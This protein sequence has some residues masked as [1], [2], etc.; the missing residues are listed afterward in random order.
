VTIRKFF[1]YEEETK[2]KV[3]RTVSK[4]SSSSTPTVRRAKVVKETLPPCE[5]CGLYKT[6]R[7]PKMGVTGEGR[8]GILFLAEAAGS[9]EDKLGYQLCGQAGQ[10]FRDEII[11]PL[12]YDLDAD[13]YKCNVVRCRPISETG[14]NRTPTDRE[15]ALCHGETWQ[16]I[17]DRRPK[18]IILTGRVPLQS[19]LLDIEI[20]GE[21]PAISRWADWCIP[22]R[23][24]KC[25]VIPQY[26]PSFFQYGS[27]K[28]LL[29][30]YR[31]KMEVAIGNSLKPFPE[32]TREED[33]IRCIFSPEEAIQVLETILRDKPPLLTLD[34]ETTGLK[35]YKTG[36][37]IV[38]VGLSWNP[39]QGVSFPMFPEIV[40]LLR[41]ILKN[42]DIKKTAHNFKFEELWA[43]Q[44]LETSIKGWKWC[45]QLATHVLDDR[46]GIKSLAFQTFVRYGIAGFKD[47][48]SP[49]MKSETSN[50]LNNI[51]ACPIDKLLLRNGLDAM[52]AHRLALDQ[53][54]ELKQIKGLTG[55][56]NLFH[57]GSLAF[58]DSEITGIRTS[59]AYF[60]EVQKG[61]EDECKVAK[62]NIM[63]SHYAKLWEK[64]TGV[65]LNP[66]SPD[67]LKKLLFNTLGVKPLKYTA[68]K[69]P[70]LDKADIDELA[71]T[72]S[73]KSLRT[74]LKNITILRTSTKTESTY[75]R[76]LMKE[77]YDDTIHPFFHLD[78]VRSYR[79]S[80]QNPNFQNI[81]VRNERMMLLVRNGIFPHPGQQLLEVDFGMHEVR[82]A[83]CFT[84]DP[85]LIHYCEDPTSD[86]HRDQT[87]RI[88]LLQKDRINKPI[89]N[90][91]KGGFVFAQFY[92]SWYA[93]CAEN[94]WKWSDDLTLE[95]GMP[96]HTHLKSK[97]ISTLDDFS[98][99][100]RAEEDHFWKKFSVY[101]QWK[102]KWV[103]KYYETGKVLL[104][105]GF[106]RQGFL[107]RNQILNTAIQG[108]A[109]HLLLWSFIELMKIA[110]KEDWKSRI[111]AQIHDCILFSVAPSE[112]Q[113][114][115]KL[116]HYITTAAI[117]KPHPWLNVPLDV[118]YELSG[119]DQPWAAKEKISLDKILLENY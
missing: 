73:Q 24:L 97:G 84:Q 96:I 83:A 109:F 54:E 62:E 61:M 42:L 56:Y 45:S 5:E 107:D 7:S 79:S 33:K 103:N 86:M 114:V 65:K 70:S 34:W 77:I 104:K 93:P 68:K 57:E 53:M 50:D 69:N 27:N 14:S 4:M 58:L 105:H 100:V 20:G 64:E 2:L 23:D 115:S 32:L 12:G 25:W 44:I 94:L 112:L 22:D 118:E 8:T 119:I 16:L 30:I 26:H 46:H 91:V 71:K 66:T 6:C 37:K 76:G 102:E 18:A 48:T 87:E 17:K 41:M 106:R 43:R 95:D 113:H 74:F 13:F 89:R 88:F 85:E 80:S 101:T 9:T 75:V 31:Q 78:S 111:I 47:E 40:P 72:V 10:L 52:F 21:Q 63:N 3:K 39:E 116:T 36:H 15:I 108:T 28:K 19:Y 29:K 35:P 98:L 81:P 82:V 92:G 110:R 99:H 38:A 59:M 60:T 117:K 49:F 51:E 90:L 11:T 1:D 55:A 67:Q